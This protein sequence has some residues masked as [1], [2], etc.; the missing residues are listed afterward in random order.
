MIFFTDGEHS[1][2]SED[3]S[4]ITDQEVIDMVIQSGIRIITLA[5]GYDDDDDDNDMIPYIKSIN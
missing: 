3:S 4:T 2:K 1:C 5:V